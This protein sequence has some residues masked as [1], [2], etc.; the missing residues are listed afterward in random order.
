MNDKSKRKN[1][2]QELRRELIILSTLKIKPNYS[3]LSRKYNVDR[4]TIKKY[5]LGYDGTRTSTSRSS[6]LDKYKKDIEEKLSLPGATI[7]GTYQYFKDK[8]NIG[9]YSNF[10]KYVKCKKLDEKKNNTAHLRFETEYGKQ[11]QFDWKEDISMISKYGEVFDFNVFSATLSASRLHVFWYSKFKTR[12]DVQR[13]LVKT[14]QYIGGVPKELLT[15]NMSSIFN[16]HTHKFQ[17]EFLAFTKDMQTVPKN[18]KPKHPY[19]KGK[20]E[21]ANRF[22]SWLIPYNHEF[23]DEKDLIKILDD[24]TKKVNTQINSTIGTSPIMLFKKEKDY[25]KPLPDNKILQEYLV[26]TVRLKVSN[27]SLF[28]Y[29]GKRYSVPTKFINHIVNVQEDN[30]KLYVYYSKELITI[31]DISKNNI[32]Y[33]DEH[34]IEGLKSVLNNKEQAEIEKLAKENLERLKGLN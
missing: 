19:T 28:Y 30:N 34:Y 4:R 10:Y 3:V 16:I 21:S 6:K 25:L 9:T 29:K 31:H 11:L 7:T 18:C 24:I 5:D 26:D 14:F 22:L 32:N 23:E 12:L 13:C 15:D 33:K 2:I 20:D 17:K 27:A 8:E 1:N